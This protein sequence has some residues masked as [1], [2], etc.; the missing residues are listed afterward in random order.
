[1]GAPVVQ[2]TG[3]LWV[4]AVSNPDV[5]RSARPCTSVDAHHKHMACPLRRSIQPLLQR[6]D[7]ISIVASSYHYGSLRGEGVEEHSMGPKRLFSILRSA[8]FCFHNF[9]RFC[10]KVKIHMEETTNHFP[11]VEKKVGKMVRWVG[12][13]KPVRRSKKCSPAVRRWLRH[14][15]LAILAPHEGR[16]SRVQWARPTN[17]VCKYG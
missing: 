5:V 16:A 9:C 10:K 7:L 4:G 1:M 14:D 2:S 11:A 17:S 13:K 3:V 8:R 15:S 12:K 6:S